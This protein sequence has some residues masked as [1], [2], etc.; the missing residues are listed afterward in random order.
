MHIWYFWLFCVI[1]VDLFVCLSI[2]LLHL[3]HENREV[4]DLFLNSSRSLRPRLT[5]KNTTEINWSY[6]ECTQNI[7]RAD[8][9]FV[10]WK[11]GM[12]TSACFPLTGFIY[13]GDII[14]RMLTATQYIAPLMANFDP[15]LSKNSTVFY[16]DNGK[17]DHRFT[18]LLW[19][20]VRWCDLEYVC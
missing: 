3:L 4:K 7:Q 10:T 12:V 2:Q 11:W 6:C 14:H 19:L 8:K 20:F 16:F 17:R 18:Q 9:R 15:S 1:S 5:C 13:T